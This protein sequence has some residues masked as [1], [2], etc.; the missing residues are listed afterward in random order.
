MVIRIITILTLLT[1]TLYATAL[2]VKFSGNK[3]FND[4]TLYEVIG[5]KPPLFFE[6]WKSEKRL[7][8]NKVKA[9]TPLI[10]NFYK[11]HGFYNAK[12]K[13]V[14]DNNR[15]VFLIKENIKTR[16]NTFLNYFWVVRRL[17][18]YLNGPLKLFSTLSGS[19]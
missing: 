5:L 3:T 2:P 16:L 12:A 10:V 17:A 4:R 9:L 19:K 15:I 7:D 14:I 13:S 6:F 18:K 8:P 11:S 1:Y